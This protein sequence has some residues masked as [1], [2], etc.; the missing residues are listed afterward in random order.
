M[1]GHL[2][3]DDDK[4]KATSFMATEAAKEALAR[5]GVEPEEIDVIILATITPDMHF[6][7][8]ACLVQAQL[9]ATKAWGFD[10]SAACSGFLYGLCTGAGVTRRS[11]TSKRLPLKFTGPPDQALR[12]ISMPSSTREGRWDSLRWN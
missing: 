9:G 10:L 12:I 8:A 6:P 3:L 4:E 2:K 11:P 5:R 7:A 1:L